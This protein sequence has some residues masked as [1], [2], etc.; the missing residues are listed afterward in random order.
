MFGAMV[1]RVEQS[2][3]SLLFDVEWFDSR[4]GERGLERDDLAA[5]AGLSPADL[6]ALLDNERDPTGDELRAFAQLLEADL[7]EVSLKAGVSVRSGES[8]DSAAR[9]DALDA[10]LDRIDRWLDELAART[11]EAR[12]YSSPALAREARKT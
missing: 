1:D 7:V 2:R 3:M 4:L 9:L 12:D 10:R 6:Q 5:A 11:P 8:N